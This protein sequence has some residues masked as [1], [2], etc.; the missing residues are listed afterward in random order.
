M[1]NQSKARIRKHLDSRTNPDRGSD[2]HQS[3]GRVSRNVISLQ[4]SLVQKSEILETGAISNHPMGF[5]VDSRYD[6]ERI[7]KYSICRVLRLEFSQILMKVCPGSSSSSNVKH[8]ISVSN[9][10]WTSGSAWRQDIVSAP[11]C[12]LH[13]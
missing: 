4:A 3:K 10:G 11:L 8:G 5:I 1:I 9:G 7:A 2:A 12:S 6:D 13:G